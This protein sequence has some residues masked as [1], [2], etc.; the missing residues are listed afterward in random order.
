MKQL[1]QNAFIACLLLITNAIFGQ[2]VSLFQQFNGRYDFVFIGNTLNPIENSFQTTPAVLTSSSA[3][4]SLNANDQIEKAYLYWAGCGPGDFDVKLNGQTIRA[5]RTFILQRVV[6]NLIFD[7]FSAFKEVTDQVQATGN[8]N[9]TLSD[10]DVSASIDFHSQRSTNFAGWAIIVI[11]KNPSLTLNQLNVYDGMQAVPDEIN[12]TLNSLNV[13]DNNDAKIGFLAWE[14]DSGIAVNETLR[15]NGTSIGNPPLN[16]VNNAFNGTN[17][18]TNSNVLYNMDLDVYPIQNNISIGDTSA[19]IQLTSSQDFVMINAIVTKLNSQLP[20]AMIE[21]NR[22]EKQ[23]D[24]RSIIAHY[25]VLNP[26]STA[27]LP[28][29]TPISIYANNICL[30]TVYTR[31]NIP[32][33]GEEIGQATVVIPNSIPNNFNLKLVVDET[34]AGIGIVPELNELNN[35]FVETVA[36]SIAPLF[37]IV[38]NIES[39]NLGNSKG[40]FN[41]SDYEALVKINSLDIVR[42]FE[43]QLNAQNNVNSIVNTSNY[44]A[45]NTPKTIFIR[46]ENSEGCYSITSFELTTKNCPPVVYNFVSADNDGYNDTFHIE[47]LKDIFLNH[48]ISIYNRWGKLVWTGNNN[49]NEWD[50]FANNGLLMDDNQIPSGTYY[51]VIELNDIDYPEPLTG[52]MYLTK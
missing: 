27:V 52:Y 36:L 5:D 23:C 51:Y 33:D 17:S 2:D 46:I 18:M 21:I 29:N 4:L 10:L 44:I 9:Y 22:V 20:D 47:G 42:F 45:L 14:G 26:N 12:I 39:C 8:G 6:S 43:S 48:K 30:S 16:P 15:I 34:S 24:S 19:Q 41:F 3:Q 32:I 11:Y 28:L 1:I 49:S 7:Y 37:N 31:L 13:I 50:G 35:K 25:R 40:Q 38:P